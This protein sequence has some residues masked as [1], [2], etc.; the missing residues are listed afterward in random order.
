MGLCLASL[1]FGQNLAIIKPFFS[2]LF[3]TGQVII[4]F[5]FFGFFKIFLDID[6]ADITNL[7]ACKT[8]NNSLRLITILD[9][10]YNFNLF[11]ES[12]ALLPYDLST[13]Q[14]FFFLKKIF[15]SL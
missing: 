7:Q 2:I 15:E 10:F 9:E 6:A 14:V 1:H 8:N 3:Q 4:F 12:T 5:P 13:A 11:Y